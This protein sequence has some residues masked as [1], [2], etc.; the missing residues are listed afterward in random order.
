MQLQVLRHFLHPFLGQDIVE[1]KY[2]QLNYIFCVE[3]K[4]FLFFLTQ[5]LV[6]APTREIAVQIR[7]VMSAIGC[8]MTS[9][10]VHAFIGGIPLEEDK[11][12]VK[13]CHIAVGSPG[14]KS[15]MLCKQ[16]QKNIKL[17]YIET[18]TNTYKY[19]LRAYDVNNFSE[20]KCRT[21]YFRN[22]YFPRVVR[23][24]NSL[25]SNIKSLSSI[26]SFKSKLRQLFLSNLSHYELPN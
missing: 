7:D 15:P 18:Q 11:K 14:H 5:V 22:S 19:N 20:F 1:T 13:K 25:E 8:H 21:V 26:G 16:Y 17:Q 3:N 24:W 9:L 4:Q 2:H 12:L 10:G 23:K 6:L